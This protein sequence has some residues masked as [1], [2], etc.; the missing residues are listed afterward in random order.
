MTMKAVR[1]HKTGGPE[2]LTFEDVPV[3]TPLPH[4]ALVRVEAA[5]VNFADTVRRSGGPYPQESPLPFSP[6]GE[7]AG[8]VE[9][10]GA[11]VT[12]LKPGARV[13][14]LCGSGGYAQFTATAADALFPI[15]D[16]VSAPEATALLVQGLTA[17]LALKEAGRMKSGETVMV[18]AAAGGVGSLAVQLAKIGG[19][20][21]IGLASSA[22]K[23]RYAS[24]LGA[25]VVIDYTKADWPAEVKT[26]TGGR[27]V[28]IV[29]EMTGGKVFEQSIECLAP[30]GRSVVY[31]TA[32]RQPP[33][34]GPRVLMA[35]N[36]SVIGFFLGGYFRQRDLIG[37]TLKELGGLV[38]AKRLRLF[39]GD[40]FPLAQA[41]EAHRR[42]EARE[43][44]GKVALLPWA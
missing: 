28:D 34:L 11:T 20:R 7:V 5:G 38:Q 42:I 41:A 4:Q 10:V 15:P 12:G 3:P 27:G 9:T 24:D 17:A 2:V 19:A 13:F 36:M 30:F 39:A 14:G 6:G 35:G 18:Q 43:T 31:G 29:L 32:S 22:E 25:D 33:T 40:T 21:V 23:R 1:F 44:R 8:T 37:A 26:A 16:G